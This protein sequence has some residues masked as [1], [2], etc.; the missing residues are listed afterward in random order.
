M[1]I[2]PIAFVICSV[3]ALQ[4]HAA[5][6]AESTI[7]VPM[8]GNLD[9]RI[10]TFA[11]TPDVV[12]ELKI[13][14]GMHT[15]IPLGEDEELIETPRIGEKVRWRVEGNEKNIYIKALVPGVRTS[16][17]LVTN[18]RVYQFELISTT[19][20]SERIQKAQFT[21]PDEEAG[22]QIAWRKSQDAAREAIENQAKHLKAQNL[23]DRPI[24]ESQLVFYSVHTENTE[25]QRMYVYSDGIKTWMRL[26]PGI[27]DLPA[28]FMVDKDERGH[29]QLMPVNYTVLDRENVRDRDFIVIDRMA[30]Q[31]RLRIGKSVEVR[32]TRD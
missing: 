22:I 6:S 24:D 14:V 1:K 18:K 28:V 25:F 4:V 7:S 29:E 17:T 11:Y 15:Q 9:P 19:K 26:P 21:Y 5:P 23:S 2:H 31:W 3:F 10:V 16:L 32:V 13:T 12:Y 27:Q 30:P 20:P 8:P